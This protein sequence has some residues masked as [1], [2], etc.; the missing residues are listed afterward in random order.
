MVRLYVQRRGPE[1][2]SGLY[3]G[4]PVEQDRAARVK[5]RYGLER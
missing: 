5:S 1:I 4:A 2:G 3:I